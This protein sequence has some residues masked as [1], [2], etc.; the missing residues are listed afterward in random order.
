MSG[1]AHAAAGVAGL[2]GAEHVGALAAAY[3]SAPRFSPSNAAKAKR[4]VPAPHHDEIDRLNRRWSEEPDVPGSAVALALDA[5][6]AARSRSDLPRVQV[7]V[8]GLTHPRL[9]LGSPPR[10]CAS[11]STTPPVG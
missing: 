11:S 6:Q 8:T 9:R 4:A 5:V 2:L 7:V 1:L 3:R 10:S